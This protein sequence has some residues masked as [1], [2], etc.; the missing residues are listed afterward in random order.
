MRYRGNYIGAISNHPQLR[1]YMRDPF[2]HHQISGM[3]ED[4][5]LMGMDLDDPELMGGLISNVV[6]KIATAV[7]KRREKKKAAGE[8]TAI[9]TFSMQTTAGTAQLGPGGLTWTGAPGVQNSLPIGTTGYQIAPV[10]QSTSILD[11]IKSNPALIA[12]AIGIPVLLMM[13]S[14]RGESKK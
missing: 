14:R 3:V 12:G 1:R 10:Q 8:S 13:M 11:K 6:K 9:P 4:A 7:R 5:E 2:I